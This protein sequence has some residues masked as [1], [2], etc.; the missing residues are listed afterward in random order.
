MR[1]IMVTTDLSDDSYLAFPAA[2]AQAKAFGASVTIVAMIEDPAQAAMIYAL[3]F[4]VQPDMEVQQQLKNRVLEDLKKIKNQ[5]FSE[6]E[7][8]AVVHE[9]TGPV[10]TEII[11]FAKNNDFDLLVIST[12]GRTGLSRMLIGSVAEKVVRESSIPVL[13]VPRKKS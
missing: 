7:S 11:N 6:V 4:P 8:Q 12:H 9:A 1:K 5:Y 3:D 2:V 13:T 10:H